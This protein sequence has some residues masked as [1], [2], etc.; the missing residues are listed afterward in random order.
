MNLER[1]G[2]I[3]KVRSGRGTGSR[4]AGAL[5]T[6]D[7]DF[8]V[9][10][11]MTNLGIGIGANSCALVRVP[12]PSH[13]QD[14]SSPNGI[15]GSLLMKKYLNAVEQSKFHK[16]ELSLIN[17]SLP[18]DLVQLWT[19]KITTWENDRTTPNP[20]YLPTTSELILSQ[21]VLF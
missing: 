7:P 10:L 11:W 17:D 20:Y 5:R 13:L 18:E 9:T 4:V 8:G 21:V 3:W 2:E 16:D 1:G 6:K 12:C 19:A 14:E 15:E